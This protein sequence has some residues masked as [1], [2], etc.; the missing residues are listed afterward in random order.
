MIDLQLYDQ[1]HMGHRLAF[2]KQVYL[3]KDGEPLTAFGR[4][5]AAFWGGASLGVLNLRPGSLIQIKLD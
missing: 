3:T 4:R 2:W 5:E 1:L